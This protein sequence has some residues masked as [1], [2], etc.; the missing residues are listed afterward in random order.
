MTCPNASLQAELLGKNTQQQV[1]AY[2]SLLQLITTFA[3][4]G[5]SMVLTEFHLQRPVLAFGSC[6]SAQSVAAKQACGSHTC[7]CAKTWQ[8]SRP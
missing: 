8:A 5:L 1:A 6:A 7:G 2:A 3:P 4:L